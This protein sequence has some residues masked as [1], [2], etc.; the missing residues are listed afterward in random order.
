MRANG[1]IRRAVVLLQDYMTSLH[2]VA[3]DLKE[4]PFVFQRDQR[5]S[6]AIVRRM[7]HVVRPRT[8]KPR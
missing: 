4:I 8:T 3:G 7:Q 6:C 5:L 1:T 2:D